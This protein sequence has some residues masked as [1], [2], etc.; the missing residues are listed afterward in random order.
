MDID[1]S[2]TAFSNARRYGSGPSTFLLC[3]ALSILRYYDHKK[4]A[5]KKEKKTTDASKMVLRFSVAPPNI[6]I[7][8]QWC[9]GMRLGLPKLCIICKCIEY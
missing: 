8:K 9:P 4:Q 2:L 3:S 5:A 1:L 6:S 7:E